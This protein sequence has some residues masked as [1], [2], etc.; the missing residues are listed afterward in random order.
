MTAAANAYVAVIED[1][2]LQAKT[3]ERILLDAGFAA[4]I[5]GTVSEA[6]T[7]FALAP[8][9]VAVIDLV[10]PDG[11]GVD[12]L[13]ALKSSAPGCSTVMVTNN[14]SVSSAIEA[15]RA[16]AFD[17]IVKPL[18][19]ERLVTTVRNAFER[20]ELRAQVQKLASAKAG[21]R[22]FHSFVGSSVVMNA[23][24]GTI[25]SVAPSR[26]PVFIMG[27]SGTGKEL[28]ATAIHAESTRRSG[29]FVALNCAAIPANLMESELFGHVRGA[30]TSA[31]AD[32]EGAAARASGGTLFFDE[33]CE[34]PLE[35]QSKLLRLLETQTF[36][37]VGAA[38]EQQ[39]DIRFVSAT[40]RDP[41]AEIAAGRLREDLFYRLHVVPLRLPPLR[42]R[43][44]DVL[45]IAAELL[46]RYASEE[47]K[48]ISGFTPD[49]A[50]I[51]RS[52]GWPGNVRELKNVMR[53]IAVLGE[54]SEVTP[55]MLAGLL[56]RAAIVQPSVGI[57]RPEPNQSIKPL[58]MVEQQAIRDAL[59]VCEGNMQ[60][61]AAFLEISISTLYRKKAEMDLQDNK[62]RERA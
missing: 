37:P 40:N 4:R 24:Y 59:I 58:W 29:P 8:P 11:T 9:A 31:V 47:G 62:G 57:R 50:E 19:R 45:E 46:Q 44:D 21:R 34:L 15:M 33:I 22:G 23:I 42:E 14:A 48:V 32:R 30:F 26:A 5:Y 16:G 61:A 13:E 60:K 18:N 39:A 3:L 2:I 12:V 51:L 28:A 20:H 54:G 27:E 52:Y 53:N 49:A 17:Y 41:L 36:Q 25:S 43:G 6:L 35:L 38:R 55:D 10:L 56:Q 1:S 7:A